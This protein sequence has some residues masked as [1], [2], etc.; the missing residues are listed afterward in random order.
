MQ[1]EL[2]PSPGPAGLALQADHR[3]VHRQDQGGVQLPPGPVQQVGQGAA[4]DDDGADDG[5]PVTGG[6]TGCV[7]VLVGMMV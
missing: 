5:V 7:C 6:H 4:G 3:G 1:P 2:T